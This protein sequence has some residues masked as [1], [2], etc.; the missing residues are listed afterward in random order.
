MIWLIE[1]GPK[2]FIQDFSLLGQIEFHDYW[3]IIH[4]VNGPLSWQRR[5]CQEKL[6]IVRR[7]SKNLSEGF[8][9]HWR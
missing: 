9:T 5:W 1:I 4:Q 2:N 6:I 3:P 8:L 7:E